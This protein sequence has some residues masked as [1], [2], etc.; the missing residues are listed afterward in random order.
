MGREIPELWD[1]GAVVLWDCARWAAT[2]LPP[3][4]YALPT[5]T[6]SSP[7]HPVHIWDSTT[8][9]KQL[10]LKQLELSVIFQKPLQNIKG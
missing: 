1:R 7:P 4:P 10:V 9:R 6:S 3:G 2:E 8:P 5:W